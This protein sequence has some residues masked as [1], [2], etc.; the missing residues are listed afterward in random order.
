MK[1]LITVVLCIALIVSLAACSGKDKEE[2]NK[3]AVPTE[4]TEKNTEEK[5]V[6]D[7]NEEK[8]ENV[9]E[10][11]QSDGD[12]NELDDIISAIEDEMNKEVAPAVDP[13]TV[14]YKNV[15]VNFEFTDG[16]KMSDFMQKAQNGEYD[17]KVIH[18]TGI[19]SA[20]MMDK[21]VN[22]V[23]LR[24]GDSGVKMGLTWKVVDADEN[25]VYPGDD[26]VIE[27]TG[28]IIAELIPDWG[29]YVR[30]LYVLPENVKDLGPETNQ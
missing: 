25:T 11:K 23:M 13:H 5:N 6:K 22:S 8:K 2:D 20:G 12:G 7:K 28:V 15:D 24:V 26:N 3:D 18:I 19:M 17:N 27:L 4:K 14:D 16:D 10:D 29:M 1:K 9:K 21:S 30:Y